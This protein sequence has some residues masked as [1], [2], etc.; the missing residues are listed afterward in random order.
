MDNMVHK[1]KIASAF[2]DDGYRIIT[3]DNTRP[4]KDEIMGIINIINEVCPSVEKISVDISHDPEIV[5][6]DLIKFTLYVSGDVETVFMEEK[7]FKNKLH[8]SVS[9]DIRQIITWVYEWK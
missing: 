8:S 5:N 9:P 4:L 2:D 1:W 7:A 6:Y 3:S